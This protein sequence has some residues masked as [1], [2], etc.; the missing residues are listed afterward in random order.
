[1]DSLQPPKSRL[2]GKTSHSSIL[3][4]SLVLLCFPVLFALSWEHLNHSAWKTAAMH[5]ISPRV[6]SYLSGVE[7]FGFI[8][9]PLLVLIATV[10]LLLLVLRRTL[11]STATII[12]TVV[13]ISG[14]AASYRGCEVLSH[15]GQ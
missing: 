6:W 3:L 13:V 12:A 8:V 4:A 1:M 9:G 2:R 11:T 14:Y 5:V 7:G 15:I 10:T